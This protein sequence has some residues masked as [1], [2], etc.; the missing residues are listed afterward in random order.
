MRQLLVVRV[1][2]TSILLVDDDAPFR[3]AISRALRNAG[4]EVAEAIDG[5]QALSSL[6]ARTPDILVSDIIMPNGDGIE[7]IS[8]VKR[9]FPTV[10]ILAIS[11]RGR[12]GSLD[13]LHMATMLGVD[14]TLA[15]PFS[16]EQ[17]LDVVRGL[18]DPSAI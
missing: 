17:F 9:T 16:P 18:S 10:R 8:A 15:K 6:K 13:L 12:L 1:G 2:S 7:L 3:G 5:A 4:Y 14:A 11:G